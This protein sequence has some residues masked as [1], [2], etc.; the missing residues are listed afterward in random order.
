MKITYI[1]GWPIPSRA[2]NAVHV[3]KMCQAFAH[4]GHDVALVCPQAIPDDLDGIEDLYAH[5]DVEE[6]FLIDSIQ[7]P[8]SRI[9]MLL[10]A[11][12]VV[13]WA[14]SKQS[15]YI[16]SRCLIC[17]W[18]CTLFGLPTIFE[19]HD[20]FENQGFLANFIFN[21]LLK[22]KSFLGLVVISE[23]LK[24]HLV[25]HHAISQERVI[26][27]H[28]GAD[29][30][31]DD[32]VSSEFEKTKG[33]LN[34]GYIGHL[35]KGRGIDIIADV[36]REMKEVEFHIVGGTEEDLKYWMKTLDDV[37]NIHF[38]GYVS[39]KE[40]MGFV[41]GFDV[42]LAPY[43][44]KVGG[45]GGTG[46]TVEWMSPLKIFEYMATGIPMICSDLPVLHEILENRRNAFL[47]TPEDHKDWSKTIEYVKNNTEEAEK[48]AR[49]AQEEFLAM[50]TWKKRAEHICEDV[51][52][53][54]N[55]RSA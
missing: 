14:K 43:Q 19:R 29:P 13:F 6:N 37:P 50:Y 45:Y 31:N 48:I 30:F 21:S 55:S 7:K 9:G 25:E 27:A 18:I 22:K 17:A 42:L 28:D 26:V 39:H 1:A 47:C 33:Q 54:L 38:Y 34:A 8:K 10:Y 24:N 15:D 3:M 52:T 2:A 23:A 51:K 35:Y 11:L 46:N 36:A 44:R 49:K 12:K 53:L 5:Y 41:K 4:N 40:A 32:G 20:S 16:H